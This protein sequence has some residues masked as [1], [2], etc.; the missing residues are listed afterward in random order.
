MIQLAFDNDFNN[1]VDEIPNYWKSIDDVP[2]KIINFIDNC[3]NKQ[4]LYESIEDKCFCKKCLKRLDNSYYCK[5]CNIYYNDLDDRKNNYYSCFITDINY[6][7]NE[8][9]YS[10][11]Y[12]FDLDENNNLIL[13][14]IKNTEK[15]V[16]IFNNYKI[17]NKKEIIYSL[18]IT[19]KYIRDLVN[20]KF[21]SYDK[22]DY[23]YRNKDLSKEE[24]LLKELLFND[25]YLVN[26]LY[27][28]NINILSETL[29]KYSGIFNILD[30]YSSNVNF[31]NLVLL[32][33]KYPVFEYLSKYGLYNLAMD[34]D[35]LEITNKSLTGVLGVGK[36]YLDFIKDNNLDIDQLDALKICKEKDMSLI[37]FISD[38]NFISDNSINLFDI[39]YKRLKEYF[40][41]NGYEYDYILEYVDYLNYCQQLG[42]DLK[43]R[44]VIYPN[45]LFESHNNLL[46]RV[47]ILEDPFIDE[48][49]KSISSALNFNYYEDDNYIIIPAKSVQSLCD[50]GYQQNNCVSMYSEKYSSG[51]SQIYFLRKKDNVEKSFVT[52]EVKNNKIVQARTKY[53]ELPDNSIKE[54]LS[55]WEKTLMK[56]D[57]ID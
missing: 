15:F 13:Y 30:Y 29:Y 36:D 10:Y 28:D 33:I 25:D 49:I 8:K 56:I 39:D 5:S 50:E 11:F 46:A 2:S 9:F 4:P 57:I 48:R 55:K 32:P 41:S 54:L 6:L 42:Y 44:K 17:I 43:D 18:L 35:K 16:K 53:N 7:D 45:D 37:N 26:Y 31:R 22:I 47:K 14:L 19:K 51:E 52:I 27:K 23:I 40:D 38:V 3:I 24:L 12:I 21:I 1:I 20:N 34:C